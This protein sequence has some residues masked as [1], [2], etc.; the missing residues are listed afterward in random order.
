M[1][2]IAFTS[3]MIILVAIFMAGCTG[4][5]TNTVTP[6]KTPT[7]TAA[8]TQA[9]TATSSTVVPTEH[10]VSGTVSIGGKPAVGY[11][12]CMYANIGTG[13][14][15]TSACV[16]TD[17]NGYFS[18]AGFTNNPPGGGTLTSYRIVI[19]TPGGTTVVYQDNATVNRP[20]DGTAL[21]IDLT[22]QG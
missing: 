10:T 9:P 17:S 20:F 12:V 14:S 5:Q 16:Q 21:N 13:A 11:I 4:S 1:L 8:A 2:K 3:I 7:A 19:S 15:T 22:T 6:T 18:F